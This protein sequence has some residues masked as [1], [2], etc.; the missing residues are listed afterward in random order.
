MNRGRMVLAAL[1]VAVMGMTAFGAEEGAG[2]AGTQPSEAMLAKMPVREV[3]VFKDGHALLVHTGKMKTD[4]AGNVLLDD[5]PQPVL[6]TFWPF[7]NDEKVKLAAVTAGERKVMATHTALS[8][9]DLLRANIGARVM[10]HAGETFEG[11]VVKVLDAKT[12]KKEDE[13]GQPGQNAAPQPS[14]EFLLLQT[15]MGTKV[16]NI[17]TIDS[18]QFAQ[19]DYKT[20]LTE[21]ETRNAL[22]LKLNWPGGKKG[23]EADV[24]MM[25]LQKGIRW[26]PNYKVTVDGEGHAKFQLQGTLINEITDLKDVRANLVVGVPTFAFKDQKDPIGLQKAV[27]Q[28]SPYFAAPQGSAGYAMSN[29]IMSQVASRAER[30]AGQGG[31]SEALPEMGGSAKNE[32]LFVFTVNHISLKKGERMVVP[33]AE[34]TVPYEDVYTLDI[35]FSPPPEVWRNF[36]T[37]Q[38]MQIA[39]IFHA[40]KVMHVLR[41]TNSSDLPITTGPALIMRDGKV[42]AQGMT[43]YTPPKGTLDLP[44]TA[45][46]D[47]LVKKKDKE[48][49]RTPNAVHWN[50]SDFTRVDVASSI[51]LTNRRG[52]AVKLEITR[53]VLGTI[54]TVDHDGQSEMLNLFEDNSFLPSGGPGDQPMWW[55][56]YNW[57]NWWT[58]FNGVGRVTWKETLEAGK[59]VELKYTWHYFW[60]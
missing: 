12:D 4:G 15:G 14:G 7:S 21:E 38:Q 37:E 20:T 26:I 44:V 27:A 33:I 52:T 30:G 25:Y 47:V 5:L 28:L 19:G 45:A 56:W 46:V 24:G 42:L 43:E 1:V 3:T 48:T 11:T 34:F 54:D 32:D 59:E 60:N 49:G 13:E 51:T 58:H 53:N 18:M 22:T 40:P 29:A 10:V 35:P 31:E 16:I 9:G 41:I 50:G 6:G 17:G 23:E 57:P 2:G 39:R 55:G 8:Y 36:G